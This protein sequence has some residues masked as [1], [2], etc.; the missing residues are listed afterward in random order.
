MNICL[1]TGT[2]TYYAQ[3]LGFLRS[4][5]HQVEVTTEKVSSEYLADFDLGISWFYRHILSAEHIATPQYGIIGCHPSFLPW[6]RGAMPNVWTIIDGIPC[7]V[8][9]YWVD[10][11]IDTGPIIAQ[12]TTDIYLTDTGE[13]L[14]DRLCNDLYNLLVDSWYYV[15]FEATTGRQY[16][17]EPQSK[18]DKNGSEFL[19]NNRKDVDGIDD[20]EKFFDERDVKDMVNILRARTFT[21]HESAYIRDAD[22]KKVYVRVVLER[23][24]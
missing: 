3:V 1:L 20:L 6:G 13:T 17:S 7:G 11:G 15:E 12:K 24:K 18:L 23:E 9:I 21:G 14:Y 19:S 22:G 4:H 8:T 10:E 2:K 5:G 16:S